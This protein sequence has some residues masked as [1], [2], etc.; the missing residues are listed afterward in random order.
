MT[1]L[2][3]RLRAQAVDI[4]AAEL[5][6]WSNTMLAA[7]DALQQLTTTDDSLT[8]AYLSGLHDAQWAAK[9]AAP[10]LSHDLLLSIRKVIIKLG[11]SPVEATAGSE[12]VVRQ[13]VRAVEAE[14]DQQPP[15]EA[16]PDDTKVTC[17]CCDHQFRAIP[18]QVQ[19]DMLAAGFGPQF[20]PLPPHEARLLQAY[21]QRR[22]A[23][24]RAFDVT[25]DGDERLMQQPAAD[26]DAW[27]QNPYTKALMKS[28]AEDYV[29]KHDQQPAA[30]AQPD[31]EGTV[32]MRKSTLQFCIR[33]L[34]DARNGFNTKML[35]EIVHQVL[36]KV[37]AGKQ[38]D[39]NDD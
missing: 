7:A 35:A 15:A 32:V 14:L 3:E 25:P 28:I 37:L 18:E 27:Q 30:E 26:F 31:E 23:R 4:A 39:I 36:T 19:S 34:N 17:P 13:L 21:T 6:V 24:L 22:A 9:S 5:S 10:D 20:T 12:E 33:E 16:Q 1:S 11:W 38:E 8:A 29:P 2:I